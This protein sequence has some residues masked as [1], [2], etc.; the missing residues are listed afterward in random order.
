[1]TVSRNFAH[2]RSAQRLRALRF[3]FAKF[4]PFAF[5]A[6]FVAMNLTGLLSHVL[7]PEVNAAQQVETI[8]LDIP[9]SGDCE[10]DWIIYRAGEREGVD[11]RF[12]HAVIKQESGYKVD[13][14]SPA[15]ARGL[16]QLMPATAKR[17]GNTDPDDTASNV[18]AG[19]KYLA[20]L[21]KRFDGDV[22]LALAGYNA[23][24]GA[25]DKYKGVPPYTETQNY[26]STIVSNYGKTYHP[27]VSP[28]DAK[29]LFHLT[30]TTMQ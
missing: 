28:E 24:E 29:L 4:V 15:G 11:P 5:F 10:L 25:V 21:L 3:R 6:L 7:A 14:V 22:S 27:M 18:Q 9:V 12:I 17:F 8:P 1:M 2:L 30:V 16:M 13:A 23:G 26:V 19:T 20:W